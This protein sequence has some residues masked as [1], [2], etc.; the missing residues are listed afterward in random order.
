MKYLR[1]LYEEKQQDYIGISGLID[2]YA[3]HY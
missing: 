3:H 1:C 2:A